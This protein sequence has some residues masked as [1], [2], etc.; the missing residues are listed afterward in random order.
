MRGFFALVVFVVLMGWL[1]STF[2]SVL[3]FLV[4]WPVMWFVLAIA[5]TGD[6]PPE[7]K[8]EDF[9]QWRGHWPE[10][11]DQLYREALKRW[12]RK[13]ERWERKHGRP[14]NP[15]TLA[16]YGGGRASEKY[17]CPM[18]RNRVG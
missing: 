3:G 11:T 2:H 1:L 16:E 17:C 12:Q 15:F 7:P 5:G 8:R 14:Y 9:D 6:L 10:R 18:H 4:F 13:R